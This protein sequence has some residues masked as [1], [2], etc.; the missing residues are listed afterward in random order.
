MSHSFVS[1][2]QI[3][4]SFAPPPFIALFWWWLGTKEKGTVALISSHCCPKL[5]CIAE[6]QL[7]S[8]HKF[9]TCQQ[10]QQL[11]ML[12]SRSRG[13]CLIHIS[14]WPPSYLSQKIHKRHW[15]RFF[16]NPNYGPCTSTEQIIKMRKL[17]TLISLILDW[18]DWLL[19]R[20]DS[21]KIEIVVM[22]RCT[23]SALTLRTGFHCLRG[24]IL[25]R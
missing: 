6:P 3:N 8:E 23:P 15:A 4:E 2:T 9:F 7:S 20:E 10:K 11:A 22:S 17:F 25:I 24:Y 12:I 19:H 13:T 18:L 21:R 16:G 5:A 14:F 1:K